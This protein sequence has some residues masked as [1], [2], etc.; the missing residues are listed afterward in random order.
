MIASIYLGAVEIKE[1]DLQDPRG[2]DNVKLMFSFAPSNGSSLR[3]VS[4]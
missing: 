3:Q 1:I 4:F 2:W